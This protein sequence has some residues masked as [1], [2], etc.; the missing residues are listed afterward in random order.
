M[1]ELLTIE[2]RVRRLE[3]RA[4]IRELVS[5]YGFVIDDRDVDGIADLFATDATFRSQDAVLG[6]RGR[7]AII[8]QFHQ[9]FSVL[10]MT[11]HFTH[12]HIIAFDDD[13]HA[14]G[15]VSSHAELVR[16]GVPMLVAL[17]YADKYVREDGRWRFADRFLTFCY[18]LDVRQYADL[19]TQRKRMRAYEEPR[20]ADWPEGTPTWQ[21]Y[22]PPRSGRSG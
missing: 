4:E 21:A 7:D 2:Q 13:D 19:L 18:Y 11:H 9:R 20:D 8:N 15:L 16:N 14:H 1:S 5:R 6:A 22:Q 12:D 10:G 17:R 3:D